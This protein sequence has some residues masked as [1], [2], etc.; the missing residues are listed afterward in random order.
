ME[1]NGGMEDEKSSG[2]DAIVQRMVDTCQSLPVLTDMSKAA[3]DSVAL[4]DASMRLEKLSHDLLM[5]SSSD[6]DDVQDR[7]RSLCQSFDDNLVLQFFGWILG[8]SDKFYEDEKG[9]FL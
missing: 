2:V 4:N 3:S 6:Y 7:L 5:A 8:Q 1:S 9:L